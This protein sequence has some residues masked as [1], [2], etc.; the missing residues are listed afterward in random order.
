MHR[1]A[2]EVSAQIDCT[3][4]ANCCTI[5][6]TGVTPEEIERLAPVLGLTPQEFE[7]RHTETEF[8]ERSIST[9]P[10]PFLKDKRCSVYEQ[11]PATCREYPHLFKEDISSRMMQVVYNADCCP[12]D[13]NTL[14]R[15]KAEIPGWK[16]RR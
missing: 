7:K 15:L 16:T 11:R 8:G 3:Q 4:C 2:G 13:F 10:C 14:E 1:I 12:I 6:G 5:M 9:C